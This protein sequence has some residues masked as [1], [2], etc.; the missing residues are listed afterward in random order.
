M[1]GLKDETPWC[2]A[3]WETIEGIVSGLFGIIGLRP[4]AGTHDDCVCKKRGVC[5][6]LMLG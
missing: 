4:S 5:W 2:S 6:G 3:M 1:R